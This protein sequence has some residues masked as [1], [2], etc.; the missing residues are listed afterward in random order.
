[1]P[2]LPEVHTTATML[3]SLLKG[4]RIISVWTDYDSPHHARKDNIKNRSF[5]ATFHKKILGATV[6]KSYRR[7]KNVLL[8]LSNNE[9]ILIHMKMTGHLLY[10]TYRKV[11]SEERWETSESGAL[12]DSKNQFIHL[13]VS[14]SNG[15][16][17][18]LSDMRKFAKVT[19]LP[20]DALENSPHLKDIGPEPLEKSFG[21]GE[22]QTN[23]LKRPRGKIK[24]VLMDPSVIAGIG[25]IYSDEIL[26][27][28]G[29]HPLSVVE[30]IPLPHLKKMFT[31]MKLLLKKG[32][33]L[34]GDST[35]D[36]RNPLG[37]HGK[38]H[39]HHKAYRNTAQQCSQKSCLGV[40]QRLKLGGRSAHFC[41]KHQQHF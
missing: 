12:Q 5:F 31:G 39:Y 33:H 27:E 7:G 11:K 2:E 32:I 6:K 29:I 36:Y 28:A 21:F 24:Q 15:K 41:D 16:H 26:Y 1:M 18:V 25:N 37:V 3:H 30:K 14:F 40:I 22:F 23:L 38:F 17:L 20:S 35:S 4:L 9:T 34:G 19:L 10:G 8:D 13:V